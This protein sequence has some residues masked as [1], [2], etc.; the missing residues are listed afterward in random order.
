MLQVR[1]LVLAIAAAT[2]FTSGFAHALGLGQMSVKSSLNQPLNAEIELLEVQKLSAIELRAGLASP[3]DFAR[4]GIDRQFFLTGLQFTPVLKANG[5]SFIQVTS[6]QPINEP[7]LNFMMEVMWPEG[8]LLREYTMLLDPPSYKPQP[9]VYSQAT[10]AKKSVASAPVQPAK[11]SIPQSSVVTSKEYRVK[12]N[13]RL[14]SIASSISHGANVQ[15]T[16]LAIQDLNPHAFSNGN[17]NRLKS[18]VLL[19]LPTPEQIQQRSKRQALAEV[20]AQLKQ[21]QPATQN[22]PA[23]KQID[24]TVVEQKDNRIKKSTKQDNLR[25][26]ADQGVA[27]SAGDSETQQIKKLNDQLAVANESLDSSRLQNQELE[28]RVQELESQL[29]KLQKI[30]ELTDN[31][32]ALVQNEMS[33]TEAAS[34]DVE[35]ITLDSSVITETEEKV[36]NGQQAELLEHSKVEELEDRGV[37]DEESTANNVATTEVDAVEAPAVIS[38]PETSSTPDVSAVSSKL[39]PKNAETEE[40]T[41]SLVSDVLAN[42]VLVAALGGGVLLL[43]LLFLLRKRRLESEVSFDEI[44]MD[45]DQSSLSQEA[46]LVATTTGVSGASL[47]KTESV[48]E[49]EEVDVLDQVQWFFDQESYI[50]ASE[51]LERAIENEPGRLEL[52]EKLVEAYGHLGKLEAF[53]EQLAYLADAG[54]SE[55]DLNRFKQQF[56]DLAQVKDFSESVVEYVKP[57]FLTDN[58]DLDVNNLA[59]DPAPVGDNFGMMLDEIQQS[60]KDLPIE[61][62]EQSFASELVRVEA[63]IEEL[64]EHADELTSL[65]FATAEPKIDSNDLSSLELEVSLD[66]ELEAELDRIVEAQ[67]ETKEDI[68]TD[69]ED[70]SFLADTDMVDTKLS[71]ATTYID[72]GELESAKLMLQEVMLEGTNMQKE[73]AEKLLANLG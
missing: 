50:Q 47:Y 22:K 33:A 12:P 48:E 6:Q 52:H 44:E 8:R 49:A 43:L 42:P 29:E 24:A 37:T 18:D 30:V 51:L 54:I 26:V 15:Q 25:L 57:E 71:L 1:K 53:Q 60:E 67:S 65:D 16:M 28:E 34:E 19:K 73:T 14:W 23:L 39:E 40:A 70:M 5:R 36:D 68:A 3:A 35:N 13:D 72:M 4:A 64:Q 38:A 32:L 56:P 66:T 41:S 9:V 20:N 61:L 27:L 11:Q 10:S 63:S 7:Y 21:V 17:I 55:V 58:S 69:F 45:E 2:T 31:Q 62:N 59:E 46:S